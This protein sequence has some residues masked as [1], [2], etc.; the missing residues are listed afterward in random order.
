MLRCLAAFPVLS[1]RLYLSPDLVPGGGVLAQVDLILQALDLVVR[2]VGHWV[3]HDL[4]PFPVPGGF[5]QSGA[6]LR[7]QD[8]VDPLMSCTLVRGALGDTHR[9]TPDGAPFLRND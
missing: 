6:D 8:I 9:V 4:F 2:G 3:L 5:G 1:S 7:P